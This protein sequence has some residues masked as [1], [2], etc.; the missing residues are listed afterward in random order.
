M[1]AHFRRLLSQERAKLGPSWEPKASLKNSG[2]V[3]FGFPR[4]CPRKSRFWSRFGIHFGMMLE[5]LGGAKMW[6][7]YHSGTI[8]EHFGCWNGRC[9]LGSVLGG[10]WRGFGQLFG[11]FLVAVWRFSRGWKKVLK[12]G[13][14]SRC[15]ESHEKG[16]TSPREGVAWGTWISV[17]LPGEEFKEG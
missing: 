10:F 6:F 8:F 7:S 13:S 15:P 17:A 16:S 11:S 4:A 1:G 2:I 3:F 14:V 12:V 5:S 9:Y